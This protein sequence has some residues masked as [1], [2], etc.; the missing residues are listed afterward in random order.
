LP[1]SLAAL[2][3]LILTGTAARADDLGD[4]QPKLLL[5]AKLLRRLKRDRER[6]TPRWLN[7]ENRVKSSPQST[8]RG[9]ELALYFAITGDETMGKAATAWQAAHPCEFRQAALIADWVGSPVPAATSECPGKNRSVLQKLRDDAFLAVAKGDR[10][11]PSEQ[12]IPQAT[13]ID[14]RDGAPLY[15]A[16]EYLDAIRSATREDLRERDVSYF[17]DLPQ[18]FLL[19]LTPKQ[20]ANP[21]WQMHSAA[22][23]LVTLD[24]NLEGSQFL[25]SWAVDNSQT[26]QD[27]PGVGYEF[28]WA[29]PYLPGVS[30]RNMEPALYQE[31]QSRLIARNS[32]DAD[33]CRIEIKP[34]SVRNDNC[35]PDWKGKRMEFGRL[36]LIPMTQRCIDVAARANNASAVLWQMA[37]GA[38][39]LYAEGDEEESGNADAAGMWRVSAEFRGRVCLQK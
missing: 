4:R 28:L 10:P 18:L 26:I 25:Q 35:P 34:G 24:P 6:Q 29:D 36:A 7:F 17:A 37:P 2:L 8:E 31:K 9:F 30:Y 32:W 20:L 15:A 5:N 14:F 23:A 33:A 21:G 13:S 27:G 11:E 19:S 39:L 38:K 22:L 12:F 16:I 3:I 1:A